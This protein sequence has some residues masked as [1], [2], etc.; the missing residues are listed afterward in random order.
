MHFT[1]YIFIFILAWPALPPV[2]VA[3]TTEVYHWVDEDGVAHFSQTAPA[4][5]EGEVRKLA[6]E[7]T[8]PADYDPDA[9]I[10]GVEQ[11]AERMRE[12]REARE[13][14]RL[15][16]LE[17]RRKAEE[18][19]PIIIYQQQQPAYRYPGYFYPGLPGRPPGIPPIWPSP[20]VPEPYP[21]VPFLPS[22]GFDD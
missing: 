5:A 18:Q 7:D 14:R 10:F 15:A 4:K 3:Q 17:A 8:T 20:P 21:S 11:Q 13:E 16:R 19:R 9:D 12:L 6:L 1:S 2:A 22:P